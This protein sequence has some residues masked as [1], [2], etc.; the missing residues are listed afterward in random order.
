MLRE[1][2]L[3]L[4]PRKMGAKS[5][6]HKSSGAGTLLIDS[7]DLRDV[8]Q[9]TR[10]SGFHDFRTGRREHYDRHQEFCPVLY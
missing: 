2:D 8:P 7:L 5:C 10:R 6:G 4:L 9:C 3:F 1:F